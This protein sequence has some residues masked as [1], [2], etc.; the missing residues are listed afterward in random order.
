VN[1]QDL[2]NRNNRTKNGGS[3][4]TEAVKETLDTVKQKASSTLDQAQHA[5][6]GVVKDAVGEAKSAA[7]GVVSTATEEAQGTVEEQKTRAADRIE[8]V[9]GALRQTGAQLEAQDQ[10]AIA[11]YTDAAAEQLERFSDFLQN[12][13]ATELLQ[14]VDRFARRQPELFV[15]GALAGGFLI[16]RFL[17]STNERNRYSGGSQYGGQYGSQYAGQYSG[18]RGFDSYGETYRGESYGGAYRETYGQF[19]PYEGD[20]GRYGHQGTERWQPE[21]TESYG[22]ANQGAVEDPQPSSNQVTGTYPAGERFVAQQTYEAFESE[23][24][25]GDEETEARLNRAQGNDVSADA[26][27]TQGENQNDKDSNDA[28]GSAQRDPYQ[29]PGPR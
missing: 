12:R 26:K 3:E 7:S 23:A 4:R 25:L 27:P 11:Q 21:E 9:A 5:V 29:D 1:T 24:H 28:P 2:N 18:Q 16:G 13:N 17:K 6:S 10:G 8:S 15:A 14:E 20:V 22:R 19:E